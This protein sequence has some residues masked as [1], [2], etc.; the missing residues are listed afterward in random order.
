MVAALAACLCACSYSS[1]KE[2]TEPQTT[3][4]ETTIP[5]PEVSLGVLIGTAIDENVMK[6]TGIIKYV[7][8]CHGI[9]VSKLQKRSPLEIT[10]FRPG[11]IIQSIGGKEI[12]T[13]DDVYIALAQY[14]PGDTVTIGTFRINIL[15]GENEYF[16]VE[17]TFPVQETTQESVQ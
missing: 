15:N 12:N 9:Y 4:E 13:L 3:Q 5:Q 10:K 17:V 11:D 6:S 1:Q 7:D 16:D 2:I 8:E 14:K